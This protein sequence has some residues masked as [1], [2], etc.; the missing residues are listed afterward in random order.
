MEVSWSTR[1]AS[2]PRGERD[3]VGSVV[4]AVAAAVVPVGARGEGAARPCEVARRP[5]G[6]GQSQ[7]RVVAERLR[8]RCHAPEQARARRGD[9]VRLPGGISSRAAGARTVLGDTKRQM[10]LNIG[11][12]DSMNREKQSQSDARF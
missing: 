12:S 9:L 5:P 4:R 1:V 2:Y 3:P 8:P 10:L 6:S 7:S 11:V